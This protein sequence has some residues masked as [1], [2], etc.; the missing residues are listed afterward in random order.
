MS[1]FITTNMNQIA[2]RVISDGVIFRAGFAGSGD[3]F[4]PYID[5]EILDDLAAPSLL[6]GTIYFNPIAAPM[7]FVPILMRELDEQAGD[8]QKLIDGLE[9]QCNN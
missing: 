7:A 3:Y 1:M 8:C 9:G 2:R 4:I 6:E 5:I